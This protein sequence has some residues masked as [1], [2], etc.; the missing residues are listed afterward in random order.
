[1]QKVK[2]KVEVY[3]ISFLS[4]FFATG[5][6]SIEPPA[7]LVTPQS[8]DIVRSLNR[9]MHAGLFHPGT[10]DVPAPRFYDPAGSAQSHLAKE[11]ISQTLSVLQQIFSAAMGFF[12]F[13]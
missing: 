10:N 4:G 1:M 13:A 6:K 2:V 11:R 9:P 7:E 5:H 8:N 12:T 3:A